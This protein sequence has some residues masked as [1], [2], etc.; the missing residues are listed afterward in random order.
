MLNRLTKAGVLVENALFATLDAT[1]RKHET[2]DGRAYTLA[3]TVG[4]VRNLP[5]QLVEAF[6][7]TLEEIADADVLVHV[8]DGSHPDPAAQLSTVR[9]VIGEVGARDIPELVV[10]NKSDLV[11]ARR[12]DRPA[13]PRAELGVRL[14]AHGRGH[15]RAA[16]ADR[17]ARAAAAARGDVLWCRMTAAT[18][19]ARVHDAGSSS[20]TEYE[21]GGTLV[22]AFVEPEEFSALEPF[23]VVRP[24]PSA[25]E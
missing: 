1:V 7:S 23:A 5:H 18:S 4:F 11:S 3:D 22:H 17:R 14:G 19:I 24:R 2:P 20:R 9:D 13:R 8:V 16:R 10:F 12:P 6:R 15:R 25:A 21:E